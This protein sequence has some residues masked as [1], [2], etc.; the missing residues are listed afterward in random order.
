MRDPEYQMRDFSPLQPQRLSLNEAKA[1]TK[2]AQRGANMALHLGGNL[3]HV[4]LSPQVHTDPLGPGDWMLALEWAGA[5]FSLELPKA[6][7]DQLA[8]PLLPDTMLPALP[9]ELAMAVLEAS[10]SEVIAALKSLGRGAPQLLDMQPDA[11]RPA[12]LPHAFS[13]RLRSTGDSAAIAATLYSDSLGLLLVAGM[14]GKR[15]PA[16]PLLDAELPLKLPAE[17]G[18]TYLP[19]DL[20]AT[21]AI[22]D[23]VLMDTCHVGADRILWLSANG[24][25]GIHVHLPEFKPSSE[26][27]SVSEHENTAPPTLTVIQAWN[28]AMPAENAPA[29]HATS[30]DAVPIRLSF[31][32]GEVTLTVAEAR[33]LQPGQPIPLS[34]PL[35]GAVNIRANGALVGHG[36]L[37]EIEGQ[38]GVSIRSLFTA[39]DSGAL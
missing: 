24:S 31:D 11:E 15:A 12:S 9:P 34:R 29:N 21:L 5:N 16:T 22:G 23:V 37:V 32:I 30:I 1:R 28:S 7:A 6:T 3:W 25:A 27:E 8:G 20:L 39:T 19:K 18:V 10:L 35:A 36:D 38:L 2:I 33:A 13:L 17:I 14:V 4:D 26:H